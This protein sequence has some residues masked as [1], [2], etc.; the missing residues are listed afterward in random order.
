M[1]NKYFTKILLCK[2]F[3]KHLSPI[4]HLFDLCKW[5]HGMKREFFIIRGWPELLLTV[6]GVMHHP[7][8]L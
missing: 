6:T 3:E 4:L 5:G 8:T 1:D 7:S 2:H